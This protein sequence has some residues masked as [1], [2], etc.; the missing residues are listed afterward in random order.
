MLGPSDPI[1]RQLL[2]STACLG[3]RPH[4]QNEV[5]IPGVPR[6]FL[7]TYPSGR[8]TRVYRYRSP[9]TGKK[10]A[11]SLGS[12][13][14][15]SLTDAL[16]MVSRIEERLAQGLDP[17]QS[18]MTLSD[19][20]DQLYLPH[21]K[22]NLRSW[23]DHNGRFDQHVRPVLGTRF[24]HQITTAELLRLV[25]GLRPS[26]SGYRRLEKLSDATVNRVIALLKVMFSR[27]VMTGFID[28]NPAR[29]LKPRRER[30]QRTRILRMEEREE[31]FSALATAPIKVQLLIKLMIL[32][33]MRL[34]EALSCRWGFVD[35]E[36]RII[37]LPDSKSGRPRVI[38]LSNEALATCRELMA[39]RENDNLFPGKNGRH[40]TR[41]GR[42]F[43]VLVAAAGTPGLWLHDLRRS[44]ATLA[45]QQGASVHDVSRLL[46]HQ[47][48]STTERYLVASD[49]RLHVAASRVGQELG[50]SIS[51]TKLDGHHTCLALSE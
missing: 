20:F 10:T 40:M 5:P 44:F 18:R 35:L 26:A 38:P 14:S 39:L 36:R 41:P 4:K 49:D 22:Q 28:A 6:L 48:T 3:M 37:Q 30:N 17:R 2:S 33:G 1:T 46:G 32:T 43:R 19:W 11:L 9:T 42:Q 16:V 29:A 8:Q 24:V 47:S 31:F 21:I 27:L 7:A 25:D 51:S 50:V 12:V 13:A 34:G 23:H 45:C 15:V